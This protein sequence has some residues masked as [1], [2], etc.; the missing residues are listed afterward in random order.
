MYEVITEPTGWSYIVGPNNYREGP[1]RY[2]WEAEEWADE[3]NDKAR[4]KVRVGIAWRG[5]LFAA[6]VV[7]V[8]VGAVVPSAGRMGPVSA[9]RPRPAITAS[10]PTT[11]A[12]TGQAGARAL[13]L[14][15]PRRYSTASAGA[16]PA[17]NAIG[18]AS[19]NR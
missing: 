15:R 5:W 9:T 1:I 4:G 16:A 2:R 7:A 13:V 17:S 6:F 14:C 3:M 19:T 8:I 18:G 11:I 12:A 10:E